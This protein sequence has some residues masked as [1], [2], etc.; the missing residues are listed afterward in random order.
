MKLV[1]FVVSL[2]S[3]TKKKEKTFSQSKHKATKG[4]KAQTIAFAIIA[5]YKMFLSTY[6][7]IIWKGILNLFVYFA[8]ILKK[9]GLLAFSIKNF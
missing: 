5:I 9:I 6:I 1:H 7:F 3:E 4:T 2:F 8:Q